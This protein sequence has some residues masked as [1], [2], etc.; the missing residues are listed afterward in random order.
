VSSSNRA[1]AGLSVPRT[2]ITNDVEALRAF[3]AETDGPVACKTFS[4]LMLSDGETAESVFTTIVDPATVDPRQFAVTAHLIQE[5]VP[6]AFDA[7]VTLVGREPFATSSSPAGHGDSW[8]AIRTGNGCGWS[9]KWAC[10]SQLHWP[11]CSAPG[12]RRDDLA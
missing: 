10:R 3:A 5:W 11:I 4:S 8:N 12:S 9:T 1:V 7:R 6:K 2:S